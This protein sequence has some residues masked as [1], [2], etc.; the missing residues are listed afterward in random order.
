MS[1]S[2]P[3]AFEAELA[4]RIALIENES[5]DHSSVRRL[6]QADTLALAALTV[7]CLAVIQFAKWI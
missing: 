4:R 1:G 3:K 2:D 7:L 6:P 5:R